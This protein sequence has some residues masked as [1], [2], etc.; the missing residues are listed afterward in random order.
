MIACN[1]EGNGYPIS[2][3]AKTQVDKVIYLDNN[4][5]HLKGSSVLLLNSYPYIPDDCI[6]TLI[7]EADTWVYEDALISKYIKIMNDCNI[8]WASARWYDRFH[9]LAT[10]FALVRTKYIKEHKDLFDFV[11]FPECHI[12]NHL[13]DNNGRYVYIKENMQT[14]IPSYIHFEWP[15]SKKGRFNCFPTGKMVTHHVEDYKTGFIIK[16]QEFNAVTG[17]RYFKDVPESNLVLAKICMRLS[18]LLQT[19]LPK[20]SWFGK[21][22]YLNI[23]SYMEKVNSKNI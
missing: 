15:Y 7:L 11:H 2:E 8:D 9:S 3:A 22:S 4:A 14:L 12:A 16:K 10:D 6:Y 1:G 20:R 5:G 18:H 19:I 23:D 21:R 17:C 13:R